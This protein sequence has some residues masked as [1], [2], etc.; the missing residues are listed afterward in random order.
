MLPAR[1]RGGAP[2]GRAL[3]TGAVELLKDVLLACARPAQQ[4]ALTRVVHTI[5]ATHGA[6]RGPVTACGTQAGSSLPIGGGCTG[7]AEAAGHVGAGVPGPC[8]GQGGITLAVCLPPT[9]PT[10]HSAH[11]LTTGPAAEQAD[12]PLQA[13]L[14]A[15]QLTLIAVGGGV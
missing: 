2:H 5:A 15:L 14:C 7:A 8:A 13:A 1:P 12:S 3:T 11:S 9:W 10:P 4:L 6:L